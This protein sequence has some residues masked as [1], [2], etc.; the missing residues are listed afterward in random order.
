[1]DKTGSSKLS[2]EYKKITKYIL[3]GLS[4]SE[5]AE[6]MNFS[7]SS[8]SNRINILFAKFH[9]KTKHEF[10]INIFQEIINEKQNI[11]NSK[12]EAIRNNCLELEKLKY[13]LKNII[14]FK[15]NK[16]KLLNW[17]NK[18]EVYLKK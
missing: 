7:I 4:R 6:K 18:S 3:Q 15:E 16:N 2:P 5:I 13:Y 12:E 17:I 14:E 10:I 9:V 11:I 1:M 8:I